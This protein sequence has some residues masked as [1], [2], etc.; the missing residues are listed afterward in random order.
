MR[1]LT[2][3]L[4]LG[5]FLFCTSVTVQAQEIIAPEEWFESM[6]LAQNLVSRNL[7]NRRNARGHHRHHRILNIN[8]KAKVKARAMPKNNENVELNKR[9]LPGSEMASLVRQHIMDIAPGDKQEM[10][11][12]LKKAVKK[13]AKKAIKK[14]A[15]KA[16]NLGACALFVLSTTQALNSPDSADREPIINAETVDA[17]MESENDLISIANL[18]KMDSSIFPSAKELESR[19]KTFNAYAADV[20]SGEKK[21]G[22]EVSEVASEGAAPEKK[23]KEVKDVK[24]K[25]EA[26]GDE[27]AMDVNDQEKADDKK[28]KKKKKKKKEKEKK[29]EKQGKKKEQHKHRKFDA[30]TASKKHPHAKK[31]KKQH[32]TAANNNK[33]KVHHHQHH[34]HHHEDPTPT[35]KDKDCVVYVTMTMVPECKPTPTTCPM[36]TKVPGCP[37][38]GLDSDSP[39]MPY[40]ISDD[41]PYDNNDEI[42]SPSLPAAPEGRC[43]DTDDNLIPE[44]LDI[45][46]N[47]APATIP[48]DPKASAPVKSVNNLVDDIEDNEMDGGY[49]N[50]NNDE[51]DEDNFDND[52][53]DT[54]DTIDGDDQGSV[55]VPDLPASLPAIDVTKSEPKSVVEVQQPKREEP[56]PAV[57][58][59]VDQQAKP[60]A[61]QP[62]RAAPVPETKL[63]EPVTELEPEQPIEQDTEGDNEIADDDDDGFNDPDD[64]KTDGD[65]L[66]SEGAKD[67]EDAGDDVIS[68]DEEYDENEEYDE[69]EELDGD[70]DGDELEGVVP[71]KLAS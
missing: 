17:A 66:S 13:A 5:L 42:A 54:G 14:V 22:K 31:G 58:A 24:N 71:A 23:K 20:N 37:I 4:G 61:A 21:K 67:N 57:P 45:A 28:K 26:E 52:T 18:K 53:D 19:V 2:T 59:A 55:P 15:K 68:E 70:E 49:T 3:Y 34:H 50:I 41:W 6:K 63:V 33:D 65:D 48:T 25:M 9:S 40:D 8:N 11:T 32:L 56:T 60:I 38:R 10:K 47:A 51:D 16:R 43:D 30:A 29:K 36:L 35:K 62:V 12:A 64:D 46:P 1:I 69:D 27:A 44:S 7:H 39:E